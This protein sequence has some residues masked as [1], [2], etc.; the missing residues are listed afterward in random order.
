ML[1]RRQQGVRISHFEGEA[2]VIERFE[3][4]ELIDGFEGPGTIHEVAEPAAEM[5]EAHLGSVLDRQSFGDHVY[6]VETETVDAPLEPSAE[7][8]VTE[9]V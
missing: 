2:V 7:R 5:A 8:F 4:P 9:P 1:E 3:V 6:D